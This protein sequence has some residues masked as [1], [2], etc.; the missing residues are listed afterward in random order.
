[1]WGTKA[2]WYLSKAF[3]ETVMLHTQLEDKGYIFLK[4]SYLFICKYLLLG[5]YSLA[6]LINP[7]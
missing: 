2:H 3:I 5:I 7:K 6:N 1:M 4:V